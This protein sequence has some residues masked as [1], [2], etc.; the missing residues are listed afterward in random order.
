MT[1]IT[2][3]GLDAVTAALKRLSSIKTQDALRVVGSKIQEQV[4][5]RIETEKKAPNGLRWA[6]W[7]RAYAETRG[8]QHSLLIDTGDLLGSF[9]TI[10]VGN[11]VQMGTEITYARKNDREREFMGLSEDNKREVRDVIEEWLREQ[12]R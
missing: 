1:S 9:R 8:T 5:R 3:T 4:E 12:L 7:T 2:V 6:P 11:E 10:N